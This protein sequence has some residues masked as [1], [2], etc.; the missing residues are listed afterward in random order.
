MEWQTTR[1]EPLPNDTAVLVLG[2]LSITLGGCSPIGAILGMV[3]LI[4]SGQGYEMNRENPEAYEGYG[5][6]QAGRICSIVGIA[7][8]A[9]GT[10]FFT[11]YFTFLGLVIFLASQV[12]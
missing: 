12:N 5:S 1:R 4:L 3:G 7:L 2:I 8:G 9:L 6:L 11:L 10:A